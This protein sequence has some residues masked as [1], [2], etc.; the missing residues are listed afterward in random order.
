MG[1][2]RTQYT[3]DATTAPTSVNFAAAQI[4]RLH[5]NDFTPINVSPSRRDPPLRVPFRIM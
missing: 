5:L 1:E 4:H 3:A 2:N